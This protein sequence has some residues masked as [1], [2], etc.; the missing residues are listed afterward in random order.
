MLC[1]RSSPELRM[2]SET[3]ISI[4]QLLNQPCKIRL[5]ETTPTEPHTCHRDPK[6]LKTRMN[7]KY[8]IPTQSNQLVLNYFTTSMNRRTTSQ[9][10]DFFHKSHWYF[11]RCLTR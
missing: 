11:L 1:V 8:V 9:W 7:H 2:H 4:T 6:Y 5:P 3:L 10:T